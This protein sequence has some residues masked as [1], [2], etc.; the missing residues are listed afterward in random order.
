[1]IVK[2]I[3]IG[4]KTHFQILPLGDMHIGDE[5]CDFHGIQEAIQYIRDN[6]DCY[7]I[8]N[9]DLINNALKTSK[10]DSY[11]E[12][13]TI[14][15]EQDLLIDLL[16]PIKDKI[17]IMTQ[18]N[19]EYRTSVLS[20]IDP[21]RYVAL[22]LGLIDSGR[23]TD[24]TYILDIQWGCAYGHDNR[25]LHYIVYGTHGSNS[26]G[27]TMGA[28][29]NALESMGGI[30]ANADLYLHSHTHATINYTKP[31]VVFNT[32]NGKAELKNRTFFNTNSFVKYGGYGERGGYKLT[33]T[34]PS[35]LN[36]AQR[37]TRTDGMVTF[38]DIIK[39]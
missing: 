24:N 3:D 18:G 4:A 11:R 17:L 25:R 37:R 29:A 10:S 7:T 12:T 1:M 36:I 13:M 23:Y 32:K 39:I 20:G 6:P 8:L 38:T 30:V 19:H 22:K 33:D 15:N 35:V 27:R 5:Y 14:E 26:G 21:L 2:S 9:G 34:R 28:T 16:T 31:I